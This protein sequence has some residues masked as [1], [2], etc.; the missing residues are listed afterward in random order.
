MKL[1]S[2]IIHALRGRKRDIEEARIPSLLASES[3][4]NDAEQK[5][6]EL[7][8]EAFKKE[9]DALNKERKLLSEREKAY[10]EKC[11]KLQEQ[12]KKKLGHDFYYEMGR[13]LRRNHG[14]Y[15]P[16]QQANNALGN[17]IDSALVD[18]QLDCLGKK[19]DAL[20]AA[21]DAF[22]KAP[23]AELAVKN[24]LEYIKN[25]KSEG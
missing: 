15:T 17:I 25:K 9:L 8:L 5:S 16:Q 18:L 11:D 23:L 14:Y 2:G 4:K 13:G 22:N 24:A 20:K 12:I 19:D 7:K 3:S 10:A 6:A 21:I 1:T